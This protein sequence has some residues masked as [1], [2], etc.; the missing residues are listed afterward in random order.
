[1]DINTLKLYQR[2]QHTGKGSGDK[3]EDVRLDS[4][5]SGDANKFP[6]NNIQFN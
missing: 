1:M 3:V 5:H 6:V 4:R 2:A